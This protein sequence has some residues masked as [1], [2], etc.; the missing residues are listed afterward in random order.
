MDRTDKIS[1]IGGLCLLAFML[2]QNYSASEMSAN[3]DN[4]QSKRYESVKEQLQTN[5]ITEYQAHLIAAAIREESNSL[6]N[7]VYST[8]HVQSYATTIS[9]LVLLIILLYA[10]KKSKKE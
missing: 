3:F 8:F 2:I 4:Y 6:K 1:L 7:T 10:I 9:S 5:G